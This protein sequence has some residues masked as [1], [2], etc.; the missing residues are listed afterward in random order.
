MPPPTAHTACLSSESGSYLCICC[1]ILIFHS[2]SP[3]ILFNPHQ[4][5]STSSNSSKSK[6]QAIGHSSIQDLY[7]TCLPV[8]EDERNVDLKLGGVPCAA[9][10]QRTE[11][12]TSRTH[13]KKM[14]TNLLVLHH[15]NAAGKEC[16]ERLPGE[17][18]PAR[19][20]YMQH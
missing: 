17:E 13:H 12:V 15:I 16:P 18:C 9:P 10:Q 14:Q 6:S 2:Y 5:T 7:S 4:H 11:T 20:P 19:F 3:F 8:R 1:S